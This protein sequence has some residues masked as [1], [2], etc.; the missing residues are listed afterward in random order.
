MKICIVGKFMPPHL[1]HLAMIRFAQELG[2]TTVLVDCVPN[3]VP[4]STIR[5]QW[6]NKSGIHSIPITEWTPQFPHEH[7]DFWNY[8]RN[9]LFKY[10]GHFDAIVTSELYGEPLAKI[11]NVLWIPFDIDRSAVNMRATFLRADIIKNWD[12]LLPAA[13]EF[14]VKKIAI[15]GAESTGKSTLC[16]KLALLHNTVSVPEYAK[17]WIEA[18]HSYDWEWF[19]KG[20]KASVS[21]LCPLSKHI[22]FLDGDIRTTFTYYRMYVGDP[23]QWLVDELQLC[24]SKAYLVKTELPWVK[25]VH[26]ENSG[27]FNRDKYVELL[28]EVLGDYEEISVHDNIESLKF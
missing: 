9:L 25:D 5:S 26:R 14:Y 28:K 3:E 23:P 21:A 12:Y 7:P 13:K 1:G 6:L 16:K 20:H 11:C 4:S 15:H 22:M 19:V 27:A 18:K 24:F 2:E 10:A 8:W 17:S